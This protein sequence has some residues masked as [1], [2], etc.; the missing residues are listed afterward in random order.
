MEISRYSNRL[1]CC[2]DT[3]HLFAAGYALWPK[4]KI[5]ELIG[6]I[7]KAIGLEK[8]GCIHMNDSKGEM[9]AH[10]DRH[11]HIGKGKIGKEAFGY[12]M[13]HSALAGIPKILETPKGGKNDPLEYDRKNLACLRKM[14]RI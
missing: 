1:G 11:E 10:L 14:A 5:D 7:D 12:I 6:K 8:V 4:G 13:R 3:C 2:L 9:G